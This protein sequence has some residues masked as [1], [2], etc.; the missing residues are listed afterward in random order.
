MSVSRLF[1]LSPFLAL[2]LCVCL[3]TVLWCILLLG[4]GCH[5]NADRFLV[6]FIGLLST[7]HCI[8]IL[9]RIG[10]FAFPMPGMDEAV[11]FLINSL[12]L[13]AAL[14]L[15]VS[16]RDRV[17]TKSHLRLAEADA[18]SATVPAGIAEHLDNDA[19]EKLRAAAAVLSGDALK[20]YVHVWLLGD[21]SAEMVIPRSELCG[22]LTN[23]RR[24]LAAAC[25][26]LK[27]HGFC[28]VQ[29]DHTPGDSV[30]VK[31]IATP[32]MKSPVSLQ[33]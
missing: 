31:P 15:R 18:F 20:L 33:R 11:D 19:L 24:A 7:Y 14:I 21:E 16:N 28:D 9:R 25:K 2:S 3:G 10:I 4:R 1:D 26:E 32:E 13:L 12:Y 27:R 30:R 29:L 23:D 8:Q 17:A 6:G 5:H 22:S